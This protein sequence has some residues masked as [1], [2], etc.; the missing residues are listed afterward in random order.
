[1]NKWG[2]TTKGVGDA[3][4]FMKSNWYIAIVKNNT[5][6]KC[7]EMLTK[8]GH[9]SYVAIQK[10]THTWRNGKRKIIDRI[11]FP[12]MLFINTTEET[13]RNEIVKLPFVQRFMTDTA[14]EKNE[15]MRHQVAVIPDDQIERL[16]FM[17][18]N[19]ETQVAV[20]PRAFTLGEKVRVTEGKLAGLEGNVIRIDNKSRICISIRTLG[21][22]SVEIDPRCLEEI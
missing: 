10:E 21:C 4:G 17:L 1:M 11:I 2:A 3:E 14:R 8:L 18:Q 19:A 22:A 12:A 7:S 16:R 5:E 6:K 9:E 15:F 20:E 13:R